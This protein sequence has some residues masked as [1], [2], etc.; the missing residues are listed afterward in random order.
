MFYL[1]LKR[2]RMNRKYFLFIP[3]F[4]IPLFL[5]AQGINFFEGSFQEVKAEAKK[6]NK[7][8]F[9]DCYT[10]WC[11]PCKWMAKN[12]FTDKK[13]GDFYN[14][15]FICYKMDME[16]GDGKDARKIYGVNAFPTLLYINGDGETEN[17]SLGA[18]DTAEFIRTGKKTLDRENNF[19]SLLRKY[20]A[21]DRTPEL[22]AKYAMACINVGLSYDIREYFATQPDSNLISDANYN[23]MER[24]LTDINSREFKYLASHRDKFSELHGK[25]KIDG[26]II[27]IFRKKLLFLS[28]KKSSMTIPEAAKSFIRPYNYVD[29]VEFSLKLLMQYYSN[30]K[31]YDWNE[32]KK[33]T[34]EYVNLM[35]VEKISPVDLLLIIQ[36][37]T[38]YIDDT[39]MQKNCL[40]WCD[41]LI[42]TEYKLPEVYLAKARI[43]KK[44]SNVS[45][46]KVNASMALEEGKK[47]D[48]PQL[49][50]IN[51]FINELSEGENKK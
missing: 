33:Y 18:S 39:L 44:W 8:I 24:Y 40:V 5:Q 29:S 25:Q 19:G 35:T 41:Y 1:W 31:M 47:K 34:E 26:R 10:S 13:V 11:G 17:R 27:E 32:Y 21:G 7:I 6:Q 16:K 38:K 49:N 36:T 22:L 9:I 51:K 4:L 12:V 46:A 45:L 42:K 3:L 20:K 30:G 37:S 15:N 14:A 28:D 48:N 43:Y 2:I 23:L 50:E